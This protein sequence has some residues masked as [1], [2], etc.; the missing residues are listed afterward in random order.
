M[1]KQTWRA[2]L[3]AQ[4]RRLLD[5]IKTLQRQDRISK[6]IGA[7]VQDRAGERQKFLLHRLRVGERTRLA[8]GVEEQPLMGAVIGGDAD[9]RAERVGAANFEPVVLHDI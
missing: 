9:P 7:A 1:P 5:A 8:R 3:P 2:L 6:L 4:L